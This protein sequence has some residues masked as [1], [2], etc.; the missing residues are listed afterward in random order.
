MRVKPKAEW[1]NYD[2]CGERKLGKLDV[3]ISLNA[4]VART[5]LQM[6][7]ERVRRG[8]GIRFKFA[9]Q[10]AQEIVS[11]KEG[12]FISYQIWAR[13]PYIYPNESPHTNRYDSPYNRVEL[14]IPVGRLELV[15]NNEK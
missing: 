6:L 8:T 10:G 1:H 11:K 9:G 3:A 5:F 7:Q 2:F 4:E 12:D 13:R 15:Y 14:Y